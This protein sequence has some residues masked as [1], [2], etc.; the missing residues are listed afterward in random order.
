MRGRRIRA[1]L[2]AC[3][4]CRAQMS[5][6]EEPIQLATEI[7]V[8]GDLPPGHRQAVQKQHLLEAFDTFECSAE[9][10][11]D[12]RWARRASVRWRSRR[13]PWRRCWLRIE[14]YNNIGSTMP[15]YWARTIA[16]GTGGTHSTLAGRASSSFPPQRSR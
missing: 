4:P 14:S 16:Q 13:S 5:R 11:S 3:W 8:P 10:A 1:H 9:P 7:L 6:L 15:D 12:C 2:E